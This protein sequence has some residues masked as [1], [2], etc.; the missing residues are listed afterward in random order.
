MPAQAQGMED[1]RGAMEM[2]DQPGPGSGMLPLLDDAD[3]AELLRTA[4][5]IAIVGASSL[6]WR[7]SNSVMRYLLGQGY[8]CVPV[9]PKRSEVLDQVCYPSLE[10]AAAAGGPFDI[11]DVFRRPE[12]TPEIARSAVATGCGALWL[13]LG[14]VSEEAAR[15]AGESGLAV[16]MDRC[17]AIVHRRL[18]D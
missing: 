16:I 4:R 13:Q 18:R 5:R 2:I 8:E 12:H 1:Q 11:V 14:V 3:A 10:A 15:I 7:A 17:T 6:P 9:N